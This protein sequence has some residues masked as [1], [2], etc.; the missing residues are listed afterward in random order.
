MSVTTRPPRHARSHT[1]EDR[2]ASQTDRLNQRRA[3]PALNSVPVRPVDVNSQEFQRWYNE[4]QQSSSEFEGTHSRFATSRRTQKA[5]SLNTRDNASV[6]LRLG[7]TA[8]FD[9]TPLRSRMGLTGLRT[10]QKF[11]AYGNSDWNTCGQAAIATMLDYHRRDPFQLPRD[12]PGVDGALHWDSSAA[13]DKLKEVG[14]G[15]DVVFG[16]GTTGGRISDALRYFGLQNTYVEHSALFSGGWEDL[17]D[18][19]Q[20]FLRELDTPVPVLIDLGAIGGKWYTA[21]WPIACGMGPSDEVYLANC[22]WRPVVDKDTFLHAWHCGFLPLGF[23][24]CAVYYSAAW[25]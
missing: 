19:L 24:H 14:W 1:R 9:V 6:P 21:H 7:G 11:H 25:G 16:F 5:V 22:P 18:K 10:A 13:I 8:E 4:R 17:W 3:E 15:P 23:N 12:T 2:S 20:Y